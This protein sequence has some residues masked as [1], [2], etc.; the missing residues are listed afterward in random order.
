M[1]KLLLSV[2]EACEIVGVKRSKLYELL[3]SGEIESVKIGKS[4]RVPVG[5]LTAY[6]ERLRADARADE[7]HS[8]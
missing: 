8:A 6:V 7:A 3:T 1:T 5:A 2:E 4:R